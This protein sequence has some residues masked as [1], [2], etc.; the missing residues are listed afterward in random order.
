MVKRDKTLKIRL[1]S[2]ELQRWQKKAVAAGMTLSEFVRMQCRSAGKPPKG[3]VRRL[4]EVKCPHGVPESQWPCADCDAIL[5][6]EHEIPHSEPCELCDAAMAAEVAAEKRQYEDRQ[7]LA[8]ERI[9]QEEEAAAEQRRRRNAELR[10]EEEAKERKSFALEQVKC[11][12]SVDAYYDSLEPGA[13]AAMEDL[14]PWLVSQ[15][16]PKPKPPAAPPT[17]AAYCYQPGPQQLTGIIEYDER[18]YP[19]D[20]ASYDPAW[21]KQRITGRLD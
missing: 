13:R 11:L 7:A 18:L 21:L 14:R 16:Q 2:R 19:T 6:C 8:K 5:Y 15:M 9:A 10:T 12:G 20:H 17:I 1:S 4:A 3:A